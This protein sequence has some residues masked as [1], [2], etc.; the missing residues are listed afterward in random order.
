MK[1]EGSKG[2]II[3]YK[4]QKGEG[5]IEVHLEDETVW[6]TQAQMVKLF[7]KTKQNISLHIRNIFKEGELNKKSV[8]KDSLT[9]AKDGKRYKTQYYNLDVIISVG[10]RVRSKRG[11]QFR[12]WATTVLKDNLIKGY[13][14]NEKRLKEQNIRLQDLQKTVNLMG[15]LL[16]IK[17]LDQNETAGLFKVITDYSYALTVL[18][19]YDRSKLKIQKTTCKKE[20][21]LTYKK[22]CSVISLLGK[23]LK[24]RGK[25]G[26]SSL[27]CN[28]KS[29]LCR[30]QQ[31]HCGFS[32]HLVSGCKWIAL[33][34]GRQKTHCR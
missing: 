7:Q 32:V 33:R 28:K 29:F 9:T 26:P 2:E 23:E 3:I 21:V 27:F 16:D 31:T 5:H 30:W 24:N 15:R 22:A 13:S 20:F 18:D 8:V 19:R 14:I 12:I 6:L 34:Q 1:P 4:P 17:E 10:Y 25:S 11:T